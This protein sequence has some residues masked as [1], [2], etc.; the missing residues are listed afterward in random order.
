MP[1]RARSRVPNAQTSHTV[2]F[3]NEAW[4]RRITKKAP[5]AK[6]TAASAAP[7]RD[8]PRSRAHEAIAHAARSAWIKVIDA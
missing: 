1:W 7:T 8:A 5:S 4:R 2:V 6:L 3:V